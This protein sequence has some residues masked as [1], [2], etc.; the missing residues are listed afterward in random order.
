LAEIRSS[1][2]PQ[3]ISEGPAGQIA[4]SGLVTEGLEQAG[5]SGLEGIEVRS[6]VAGSA[7]VH[8]DRERL[9]QVLVNLFRNAAEAMPGGGTLQV[10]AT[11][12]GEG[13]TRI[14][15]GDEGC[16][17]DEAFVADSLFRPFVSQKQDG[18]G[19]G[20]YQCRS[21]VEEHGGEIRV[22]SREGEGTRFILRIPSGEPAK[23]VACETVS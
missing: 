4:V 6:D 10:A 16:G 9:L 8:G 12:D 20:L 13:W 3:L 19:I 7:R 2:D 15:V 5:V 1:A 23:E 21:I 14:E 22:E 17:M 18:L 11:P